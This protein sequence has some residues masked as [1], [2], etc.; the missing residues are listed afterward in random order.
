[1][2]LE[3]QFTARLS[4]MSVVIVRYH[5]MIGPCFK[6]VFLCRMRAFVLS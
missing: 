6:A 1:M 5:S 3:Q 2:A 4:V